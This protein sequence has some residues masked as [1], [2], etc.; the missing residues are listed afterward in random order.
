MP[1][2]FETASPRREPSERRFVEQQESAK[3]LSRLVNSRMQGSNQSRLL[4]EPPCTAS[5]A[6]RFA[7]EITYEG[8]NKNS[9][10]SYK[11]ASRYPNTIRV[12]HEAA[13][14]KIRPKGGSFACRSNREVMLCA[15]LI[16][17]LSI[18]PPSVSTGYFQCSIKS[19]AWKAL[20][21]RAIL[22]T[23]S[24]VRVRT[25][26]TSRWQSPAS[27]VLIFRSR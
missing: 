24:D 21:R 11:G 13:L 5:S 12:G 4:T 16:L 26:T 18:V 8:E 7:S 20:R 17:L 22:L 6:V 1:L 10:S 27:P 15:H 9:P 25:L 3:Q 19:A 2:D 23:I 14:R